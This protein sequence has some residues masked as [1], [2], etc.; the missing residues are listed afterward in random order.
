MG[1]F[2]L[3]M[4]VFGSSEVKIQVS[5]DSFCTSLAVLIGVLTLFWA[6]GSFPGYNNVLLSHKELQL[7][8]NKEE[9]EWTNVLANVKGVYCIS[10]TSPGQ[11]YPE[12][13]KA[14]T[15]II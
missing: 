7:I 13:F 3:K 8:V 5:L 4:V 12:L 1:Y 9:P 10:E 2:A 14:N 6:I 11:L 15:T